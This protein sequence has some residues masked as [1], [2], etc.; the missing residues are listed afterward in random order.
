[1]LRRLLS[2]ALPLLLLAA[3]P[4]AAEEGAAASKQ[5]GQYV[6]LQPMALPIIVDGQLANYVFV[7]VRLN[8]ASGADTNRWRA[9]EPFLRDAVVRAAHA[10]PFTVPSDLQKIDVARLT[11]SLM[12]S[13]AVIF[14]PNVVRSVTVTSQVSSRRAR[15]KA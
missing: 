9:K 3:A 13:S 4:A 1:M 7:S 10:T 15:P 6:D 2:F 14:G 5:V 8:L 12:R 11:A